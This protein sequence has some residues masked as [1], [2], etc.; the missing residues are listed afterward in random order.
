VIVLEAG[1][2]SATKPAS[3]VKCSAASLERWQRPGGRGAA[4]S[5]PRRR[6]SPRLRHLPRAAPIPRVPSPTPDGS[7]PD[8]IYSH[9]ELPNPPDDNRFESLEVARGGLEPTCL[10]GN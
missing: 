2:S 1:L 8:W 7:A 3:Q 10:R 6:G 4:R 5:S 9:D